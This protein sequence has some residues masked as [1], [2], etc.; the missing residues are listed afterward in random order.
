[1][2]KKNIWNNNKPLFITLII[3]VALVW[4]GWGFMG[5]QT[6]VQT[7]LSGLTLG[8]LYFMV[9]SGLTLIFGL[10]GVLNFAHGAMFMIGAYSGWQFYTNPTF[11]FGLL[12]LVGAIF[13]GIAAAGFL[14]PEV[15]L[16]VPDR[17]ERGCST[18]S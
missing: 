15:F 1:M 17:G 14:K 18:A 2:M 6:F 8:S 7:A 3:L 16:P 12:P 13:T 4:L 11:I 9:A 5:R 10:M